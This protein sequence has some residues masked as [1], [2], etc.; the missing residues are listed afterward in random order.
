TGQPDQGDYADVMPKY[1]KMLLTVDPGDVKKAYFRGAGVAAVI[2]ELL[3]DYRKREDE[4]RKRAAD[5]GA[6]NSLK[7]NVMSH[8]QPWKATAKRYLDDVY[9]AFKGASAADLAALPNGWGNFVTQRKTAGAEEVIRN[10]FKT[11]LMTPYKPTE[12]GVKNHLGD[13]YE[14]FKG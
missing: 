5:E 2:A 4:E 9:E 3:S 7:T 8:L 13:V 14:A 10:H 6:R 11:K 1:R 12:A